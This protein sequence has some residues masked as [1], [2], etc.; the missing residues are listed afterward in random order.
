MYYAR[1]CHVQIAHGRALTIEYGQ[2][3]VID[4]VVKYLENVVEDLKD[5]KKATD[6]PYPGGKPISMLPVSQQ[7][8]IAKAVSQQAAFMSTAKTCSVHDGLLF[9]DSYKS[10]PACIMEKYWYQ[11][12][13]QRT[14]WINRLNNSCSDVNNS[15][16]LSAW[17]DGRWQLQEGNGG[18][19]LAEGKTETTSTIPLVMA[20]RAVVDRTLEIANLHESDLKMLKRVKT[21]VDDPNHN[22]PLQTEES[23]R[24][25]LWNFKEGEK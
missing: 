2:H 6:K 21:I 5:L 15:F 8:E 19:T 17:E 16:T 23:K 18:R 20:K 11:S 14:L 25:V 3:V 13:D 9:A 7:N 12:H 4:E 22:P 24:G 1:F 10:C